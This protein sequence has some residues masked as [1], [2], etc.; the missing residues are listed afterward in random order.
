M[1]NRF[2]TAI[3]C[4]ARRGTARLRPSRRW[5]SIVPPPV[6]ERDSAEAD[7]IARGGIVLGRLRL[8]TSFALP[9]TELSL[10]DT[11]ETE[12]RTPAAAFP[13]RQA[14][15][16][17][18]TLVVASWL[19]SRPPWPQDVSYHDFAD[20]RLILGVPH[21][22]NVVS[23]LPFL[24]VGVCGIA[25]VLR[26]QTAFRWQSERWPYLCFF[27][28]VTLTTFGSTYYHLAPDNARLFWDRLPMTVAFMGLFDA[29]I[30]E[31]LGRK[32]GQILLVPLIVLGIGSSL[33][34]AWTNDLRP[35]FLVQFY[36]MLA[37]P[38]MLL[39]FPPTYTGTVWLFA[40]LGCY[41]LAKYCEHPLDAP[42]YHLLGH[43][44]SGHTLKHLLAAAAVYC[45]LH[46]LRVRRSLER[47]GPERAHAERGGG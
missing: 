26:S 35:Y 23:N 41:L 38:M 25:T 39:L 29:I 10:H 40:A 5:P 14:V 27:I 6:P 3:A 7:N 24:F 1:Q 33:Y 43:T 47:E 4:P 34:W 36:P 37:M 11:M 18:L 21:F 20:Q 15:L 19:F 17:V 31:R 32:I 22:A 30:T 2:C 28:G 12:A 46:M 16:V 44:V 9:L 42:I 8:G 13:L 45:V